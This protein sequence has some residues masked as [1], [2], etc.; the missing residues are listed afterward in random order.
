[1]NK[2][3]YNVTQIKNHEELEYQNE[4]SSHAQLLIIS[5]HKVKNL[6]L[7]LEMLR[8]LAFYLDLVFVKEELKQI[9]T[10]TDE[11]KIKEMIK[12]LY[13]GTVDI[14]DLIE[15]CKENQAIKEEVKKIEKEYEEESLRDLTDPSAVIP[16]GKLDNNMISLLKNRN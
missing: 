12:S 1:M 10:K 14:S 8:N 2:R 16:S 9:Y 15:I 3:Q 4:R 6:W 11:V 5:F 7:K 13:D